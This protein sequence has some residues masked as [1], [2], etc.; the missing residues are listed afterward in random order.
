MI[1]ASWLVVIQSFYP[2]GQGV[3]LVLG[4][5]VEVCGCRSNSFNC[6]SIFVLSRHQGNIRNRMFITSLIKTFKYFGKNYQQQLWVSELLFPRIIVSYQLWM[7]TV[8]MVTTVIISDWNLH[9]YRSRVLPT[10]HS[11]SDYVMWQHLIGQS[12]LRPVPSVSFRSFK[13][14][15]SFETTHPPDLMM[16]SEVMPSCKDTPSFSRVAGHLPDL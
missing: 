2:I 6:F 15:P 10:L 8:T 4:S 3:V 14:T 13:V 11:C 16:C 12:A 9:G 5:E 1:T 7:S